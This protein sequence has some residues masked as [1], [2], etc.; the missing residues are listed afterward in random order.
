LTVYAAASTGE[1]FKT[2]DGGARWTALNSGPKNFEAGFLAIDS[3]G[4]VYAAAGLYGVSGQGFSKTTDGGRSWS[5]IGSGPW[6]CIGGGATLAIDPSNPG[7]LYA[8]S[9]SVCKSTDGGA[10]WT[11]VSS[12][13]GTSTGFYPKVLA[14]D[15]QDPQTVYANTRDGFFKSTDGGASW[16]PASS[17]LPPIDQQAPVVQ[18]SAFAIDPQNSGTVYIGLLGRIFKTTD[19]GASWNDASFGLPPVSPGYPGVLSL[20]VNPQNPAAISALIQQQQGPHPTPI[21]LVTSTDGGASWTTATDPNLAAAAITIGTI[22]PDPQEPG[23][24]YLGTSNGILKT[25]DGGGHWN[26]ANSDLKAIAQFSQ[27]LIDPENGTLLAHAASG[28]FRSTDGGATWSIS[29]PPLGL[30]VGDPQTPHTLYALVSQGGSSA[31][32]RSWDF[33]ES[34][35]EIGTIPA[36]NNAGLALTISP[37]LPTT[38]YAVAPGTGA[39]SALF[40]TIDGG[41][42]W[43]KS[44]P[45]LNGENLLSG[46][47]VDPQDPNT[48]YAGTG[49]EFLT[50]G[51]FSLSKSMNGGAKWVKLRG[52]DTVTDPDGPD[53]PAVVID[54]QNPSTIYFAED[55]IWHK[56]TDGG[57]SWT[58]IPGCEPWGSFLL[59]I[60]PQSSST[61]YAATNYRVCRSTDGGASWTAIGSGLTGAVNSLA[62][63][64]RNAGTLYAA[65]SSGLFVISL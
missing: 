51:Y 14:I 44:T 3:A 25:T 31:L 46:I 28:S 54:P 10:T 29:A 7:T 60:D 58:D 59:L 61:L 4:T 19:G 17:G 24:L 52:P 56:S 36:P 27:V 39:G 63:D 43:S 38:M 20:V 5:A 1:I 21:L 53:P 6:S 40:K 22:T 64:L 37:E 9:A 11:Q 42:T 62:L 2:I 32:F 18:L 45:A 16:D 34:W 13:I 47:A 50:T 35:V 48:I 23:T 12:E 55:D 8:A 65:T 30:L 15:P 57:A 41:Y 33:G 49:S 26:F